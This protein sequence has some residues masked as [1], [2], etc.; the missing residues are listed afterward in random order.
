MLAQRYPDA[1]DGIAAAAP[2]LNWAQFFPAATWA[3]VMMSITGQY[4]SKCEIDALTDAAVAACDP[5]DGVIDGIIS[6]VSRCFFD[7]FAL[8]GSTAY[9]LSTNTTIT[10]SEAA[11]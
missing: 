9:C 8:I 2:A 6:D 5:L 1:Y 11:V 10:I 7:P 3:Q 4:P